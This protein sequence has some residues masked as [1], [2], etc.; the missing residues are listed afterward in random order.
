MRK[1]IMAPPNCASVLIVGAG[2]GLSAA[3]ARVL[4][5][6]VL[7]VAVAARDTVTQ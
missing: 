7:A 4:G 1:Q 6:G 3:L 2:Q 5:H